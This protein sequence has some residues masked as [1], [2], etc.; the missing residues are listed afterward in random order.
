MS[1]PTVSVVIAAYNRGPRIA[2]T[3][4]SVLAQS[5]PAVEVMVV[6]D[7]SSDD[8]VPFLREHYP[9]VRLL[10]VP[11]AGQSVARNSGAEAAR[12][13]VVVFFDS[14]DIMLP[15]ALETLVGCLQR[16]PEARV[17]YADHRYA[18]GVTGTV[19]ENHHYTLPQYR[20]L[21]DVPVA[22]AGKDER[23]YGRPIYYTLLYGNLLQQPWAIYRD[24]FL[25]SGGFAPELRSNEDWDLFLRLAYDVPLVLTDRVISTHR[26]EKERDHVHLSAG[27]DETNTAVIRRQ[28]RA[29]RWRDFRATVILRR[30]LA[31]YLKTAGDQA[32]PTSLPQAWRYYARSLGLWPFDHVVAARALVLWPA[33][34][35]AGRG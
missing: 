14:D 18:N 9:Q 21:A 28:L 2:D 16:F 20:R 31:T 22:R 15:H 27:Q 10:E 8:T 12:G 34:M 7:G 26:V 24:T 19:H 1:E 13:K 3:L 17:A 4:D 35:L 33:R 11:H 30:R 6:D 23:L 5:E 29:R 25:A 32:R